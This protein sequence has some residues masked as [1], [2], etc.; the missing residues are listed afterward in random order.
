A[1]RTAPG[2][3]AR[4]HRRVPRTLVCFHAHPDDEA[5]ATGGVMAKAAAAGHRVVLVLATGG[6][7]GE[8]PDG[9]LAPGETLAERRA[10][11]TAAAAELLG[12]ARVAWLGYHDSGMDGEP[13]NHHEGSF[14]SA[15]LEEATARLAGILR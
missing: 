12:V 9:L 6:E 3:G 13:T 8:V 7:L 1:P 4:D 14:W 11:E 5:I 10:A 15:D 2:P